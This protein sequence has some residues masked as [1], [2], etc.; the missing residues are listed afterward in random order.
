MSEGANLTVFSEGIRLNAQRELPVDPRNKPR[1]Y[2][3]SQ[4]HT[5]ERGTFNVPDSVSEERVQLVAQRYMTKWGEYLERPQPWGPGFTVLSMEFPHVDKSVVT[6]AIG[7]PD[8][9]Y[10]EMWAKVRRA[11]VEMHAEVPDEDVPI[12]LA[13][14]YTIKE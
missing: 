13:S 14:G 9:R 10:Y 12:Y 4:K 5:W 8:R 2:F 6:Q 11:P 3:P 1:A 7:D